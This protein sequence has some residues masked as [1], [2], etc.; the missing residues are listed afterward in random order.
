MPDSAF[1]FSRK[2]KYQILIGIVVI[3]VAFRLYLPT[4][5]KNYVNKVLADIPG[6]YGHVEKIDIALIRGAYVINDLYLNKVKAETEIPFINIPK[7][8]I[9]IEWKSL[10]KGKVVSELLLYNPTINYVSEDQEGEETSSGEDWSKALT[11]LVPIEINHLE[12]H[13]GKLSYIV[14]GSDPDIILEIN[15]LELIADNLRNVEAEANTL[16]SLMKVTGST[17][18]GGQ[19]KIEG[20]LNLIKEI[21]DADV[22]FSLENV[23]I[24]ALNDF[25]RYYADL[26]FEKGK[27][28]LFS[29]VAIAN[30][31]LTGYVKP[32][33]IESKLIG[34]ED[35]FVEKL[36][37]G[38]VGFFKFAL[39][40]QGTDTLASK[41]PIEGDLNNLDTSIWTTI[42]NVL[43]N[44]W[45]KAFSQAVDEDITYQDALQ[46]L[47]GKP[48][49][50]K[51][52]IRQEKRAE[53]KDHKE[54]Q[55]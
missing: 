21:P 6:Y 23:D 45:I 19:L 44:G 20:K 37:E 52:E 43:K 9:S 12:M 27:F 28:E 29:E 54:K 2:A 1:P 14:V 16:P 39:K 53:K 7:T 47:N 10:L 13:D 50:T 18:G 8:D 25:S 4:L 40:N 36:W 11:D 49:K 42:T 33:L 24:T 32:M 3:L 31:F 17:V 22:A 26:D 30:G 35:K 46:G 34:K 15:K 48:E 55:N 51:K 38:F 5:V 41:V